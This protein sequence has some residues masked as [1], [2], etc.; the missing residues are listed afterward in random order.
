[1]KEMVQDILELKAHGMTIIA[2]PI[3]VYTNKITLNC[4]H[5]SRGNS[6]LDDL[7]ALFAPYH[8]LVAFLN[9]TLHGVPFPVTLNAI[10]SLS[11][12]FQAPI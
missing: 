6:K 1:M 5:A 8:T 9:M 2:A 12:I 3:T 10:T 4:K 7:H 11:K